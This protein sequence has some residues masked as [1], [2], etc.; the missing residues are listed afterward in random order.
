M[1]LQGYLK[2][3]FIGAVILIMLLPG[4][5]DEKPQKARGVRIHGRENVFVEEKEGRLDLILSDIFD[6]K[7]SEI[8]VRSHLGECIVIEA[9]GL[10]SYA[11]ENSGA[12]ISLKNRAKETVL[13]DIADIYVDSE[14]KDFGVY[15]LNH[16]KQVNFYSK[17]ELLKEHISFFEG[18]NK[19][20]LQQEIT[21]E[22]SGL[23]SD[24]VILIFDSGEIRAEKAGTAGVLTI[25]DDLLFPKLGEDSAQ[26]LKA[27]W[28]NPPERSAFAV[29]DLIV[30]A[31]KESATLALFIDGLGYELWRYAKKRGYTDT[32]QAIEPEPMM[33]VYP[34]KTVNNYYMFG[35]G[36]LLPGDNER[37]K[38]FGSLSFL[39]D[40][41]IIIEGNVQLY[42][43]ELDQLL[44][45]SERWG[46]NID[47]QIFET[48]LRK[49]ETKDFILAH[50]HDIDN[51]AHRYGPY[52]REVLKIVR[53]TGEYLRIIDEIWEGN[54]FVFS[55]HGLH[56][57]YDYDRENTY[58]THYTAKP[59]DIIGIF[60]D[61]S[62]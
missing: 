59:E 6:R 61:L 43:S 30:A 54:L 57:Y 8:I 26:A 50:F 5:Q 36:K 10:S 32:F 60:I 47:E 39:Q 56:E 35:T 25:A 42:E 18:N 31:A 9:S 62:N 27:V 52:S 28:E 51:N 3:A 21:L 17:Y 15:H 14:R 55:D 44:H 23:S 22:V 45:A 16:T 7:I 40:R 2:Q 20:M 19:G 58:G 24:E 53:Q 46:E 4:C 12:E 1:S 11:I 49:I 34:P 37:E 48:L 38:L 29:H 41:G 13:T 33:V